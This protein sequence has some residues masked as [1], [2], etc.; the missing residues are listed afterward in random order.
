MIV[1]NVVLGADF[2]FAASGATARGMIKED[3]GM[4]KG[5]MMNGRKKIIG[6]LAAA[7]ALTLTFAV[8][9]ALLPARETADAAS[10]NIGEIYDDKTK[11]FKKENLQS[12]YQALAGTNTFDSVKTAAQTPQGLGSKDIHVML[13]G[14]E[15]IAVYLSKA[16]DSHKNEIDPAPMGSGKGVAAKDDVVLT[17]WLASPSEEDT[18][19]YMTEWNSVCHDDHTTLAT[20]PTNMYGTSYVRSQF[21]NNGGEY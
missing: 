7:M 18:N 11:N 2:H 1:E 6:G 16:D 15:W 3:M 20:Y 8:G 19:K 14:M 5:R 12:L 21:L 4:I 13:D 17:L 10:V 9:L